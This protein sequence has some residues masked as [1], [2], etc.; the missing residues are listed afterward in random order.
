MTNG[1][2]WSR[3]RITAATR[4][5]PT[6][7]GASRAVTRSRVEGSS[8]S[9]G[10]AFGPSAVGRGPASTI[11]S[12][13]ARVSTAVPSAF[14]TCRTSAPISTALGAAWFPLIRGRVSRGS[15]VTSTSAV[16]VAYSRASPGTGPRRRSAPCSPAEAA[17]AATQRRAAATET[18]DH[19]RRI[20]TSTPAATRHTPVTPMVHSGGASSASAA[21]AQAASAGGTSRRSVG[22]SCRGW[23]APSRLPEVVCTEARGPATP[24]SSEMSG[25]T[26]LGRRVALMAVRDRVDRRSGGHRCRSPRAARPPSG[27]RRAGCG[28]R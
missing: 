24:A 13:G 20:V 4:S 23:A 7:A 2:A 16:T 8:R 28:S 15:A 11:N 5:R 9:H 19:R 21:V 26:A 12:T 25:A 10:E 17:P 3:T 27:S 18:R 22:P 14:S 6:R 1:T